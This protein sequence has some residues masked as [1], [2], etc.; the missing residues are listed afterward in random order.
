MSLTSTGAFSFELVGWSLASRGKRRL[1]GFD[2]RATT[3]QVLFTLSRGRE[4]LYIYTHTAVSLLISN[5]LGGETAPLPPPWKLSRQRQ[6]AI[7][8]LV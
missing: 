2:F 7:K 8:I 3:A 6:P 1:K 5:P 4:N